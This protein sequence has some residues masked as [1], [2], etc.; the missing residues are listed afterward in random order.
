MKICIHFLIFEEWSGKKW[1]LKVREREQQR[2]LGESN[3]TKVREKKVSR[4]GIVY[5]MDC[6]WEVSFDK[7]WEIFIEKSN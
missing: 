3:I 2:G 6:Q 7:G 1:I 4:K 5:T